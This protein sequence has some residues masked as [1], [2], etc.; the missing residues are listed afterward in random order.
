MNSGGRLDL[1]HADRHVLDGVVLALVG[2]LEPS[3]AADAEAD[4]GRP[5]QVLSSGRN[6]IVGFTS[7]PSRTRNAFAPRD[8]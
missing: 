5:A 8:G 6:S 3:V 1:L 4:V 2:E 7:L